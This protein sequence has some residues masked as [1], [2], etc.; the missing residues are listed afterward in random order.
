MVH[1]GL[2]EFFITTSMP[3]LD[4]GTPYTFMAMN[5]GTMVH[6]LVI[7]PAGAADEPLEKDGVESEI[8]DIAPGT[9][10]E[11][12]WTFEDAGMY[13]FACHIEGHYEAG[14]VLEFE[15]VG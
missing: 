4:V 2:G 15:V 11:M 12:T 8:E 7:E 10:G 5:T 13:Q 14:M 6:E 3:M 1:V 9:N